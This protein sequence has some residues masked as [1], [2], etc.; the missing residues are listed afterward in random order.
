MNNDTEASHF[1]QLLQAA[2][3]QPQPQRL[4]FVFAGAEL[5]AD[6]TP[7]QRERFD[8]GQGGALAPLMCVDKTPDELTSFAALADEA[9][10]FGPPWQV[11]F[12]AGLGGAGGQPPSD[13]KVS[14]ALDGMVDAI[15]QGRVA[16]FAAYDPSGRPLDLS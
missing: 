7:A 5:P 1:A 15:K 3:T 4:L 10:Q 9:R 14:Q 2:A 13:A 8:R 12:V 11:V 6:A 16:G